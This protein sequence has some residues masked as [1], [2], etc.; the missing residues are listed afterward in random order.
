M[1]AM[2][3]CAQPELSEAARIRHNCGFICPDPWGL[4]DPHFC[5]P[6]HNCCCAPVCN[7]EFYNKTSFIGINW[8]DKY[9]KTELPRNYQFQILKD[10]GFTHIKIFSPEGLAAIRKVYGSDV[11]VYVGIPNDRLASFVTDY[12]YTKRVLYE[13]IMPFRDIVKGIIVGNE[14]FLCIRTIRWLENK[15]CGELNIPSKLLP[16]M[17]AMQRAVNEYELQ[18]EMF[19]STALNGGILEMSTSPWTPCVSDYKAPVVSLMLPL[20]DFLRENN[21]IFIV[22]VYSW[23][24]TM[25]GHLPPAIATG[26]PTDT[27]PFDGRYNYYFNYDMQVDMQRVA[28]CKRGF[29]DIPLWIGET[30][31]PSGGHPQ[32]TLNNAYEFFKNVIRRAKGEG[33]GDPKLDTHRTSGVSHTVF[34]FEAFNEEKKYLIEHGNKFENDFGLWYEDGLPKWRDPSN[35]G[36]LNFDIPGKQSSLSMPP[37]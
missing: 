37:L 27:I 1:E 15:E 26:E 18:D 14:P 13:Q 32:A 8:S 31:W 3:Q 5:G 35:P 24:A 9:M 30:G 20:L 12:N 16:A 17:K 10:H 11:M 2:P 29:N 28:L 21:S 33:I 34:L 7:Q 36:M 6:P 4:D 22:N 19:V 25:G 23:F